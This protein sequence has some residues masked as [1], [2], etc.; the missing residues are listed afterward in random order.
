MAKEMIHRTDDIVIDTSK[1][2]SGLIPGQMTTLRYLTHELNDC[3]AGFALGTEETI[4]IA[5][6]TADL[7]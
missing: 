5:P 7:V 3:V 6:L 2:P 4:G 1:V